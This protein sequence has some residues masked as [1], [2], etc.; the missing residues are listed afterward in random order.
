MPG[1]ATLFQREPGILL[2][3]LGLPEILQW[4]YRS[5]TGPT[6]LP[7]AEAH[8]MPDAIWTVGGDLPPD[9]SIA[10]CTPDGPCK[11]NA[12]VETRHVAGI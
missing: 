7:T 1:L 11:Q 6:L 2:Q 12:V 4:L 5:F 8:V 10:R 9:S 3:A